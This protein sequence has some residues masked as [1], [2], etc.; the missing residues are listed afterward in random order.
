M[1]NMKYGV[2]SGF[3]AGVNTCMYI[4]VNDSL[5]TLASENLCIHIYIYIYTDIP[6][7]RSKDHNVL[8]EV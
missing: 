7:V 1:M 4:S 5:G 2:R 6:D 3:S 8:K